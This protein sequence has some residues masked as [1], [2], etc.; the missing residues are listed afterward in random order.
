MS[1]T[2]IVLAGVVAISGYVVISDGGP[3]EVLDGVSDAAIE[4]RSFV[5]EVEF[6]DTTEFPKI[7]NP[8]AIIGGT[9]DPV[10][11]GNSS[12]LLFGQDT[13]TETDLSVD[14][15]RFERPGAKSAVEASE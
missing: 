13:E 2:R 11:D 8:D 10:E 5:N 9:G 6:E 15:P 14:A 1:F 12:N 4:A 3:S 7:E